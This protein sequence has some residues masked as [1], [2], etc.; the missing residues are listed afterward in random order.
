MEGSGP[1]G[2]SVSLLVVEQRRSM[3]RST[4][5]EATV[6]PN[7]TVVVPVVIK[8]A[9]D[10]RPGD[11]VRIVLTV[12][13]ADGPQATSMGSETWPRPT[14]ADIRPLTVEEFFALPKIDRE[15]DPARL[16]EEGEAAAAAE[17]LAKLL[18]DG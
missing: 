14:E 7:G 15:I 6:Q 11:R 17:F 4:I 12:S 13:R 2:Q 1:S 10:V 9:G 3:A 18:A 5:L 16:I 8:S